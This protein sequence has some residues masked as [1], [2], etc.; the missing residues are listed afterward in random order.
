MT[1]SSASGCPACGSERLKSAPI[2]IVDSVARLVSGRRRYK[3]AAC[4]WAGWRRRLRRRHDDVPSLTPRQ[5]PQSSAV[6]FF[7]FVVIFLVASGVLLTRGCASDSSGPI[8]S[9]ATA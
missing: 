2:P 8:E 5:K 3:C 1:A 9:G 7:V 4:G 6:W